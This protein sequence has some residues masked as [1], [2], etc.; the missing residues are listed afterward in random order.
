MLYLRYS[1]DWKRNAD[2]AIREICD[3][4]ASDPHKRILIVPE[5][6]SFD[7]ELA[8]CRA[9]GD[10]ISRYAEVL[11]FT[12][13][14]SRVFSQVGGAAI[15][16]LDKSGRLIAMA[17]ALEQLRPKLKLYGRHVTKPEFLQQ[18]LQVVDEFHGYGLRSEDVRR[19]E[20]LL[21]EPLTEKLEELCLILESYDAVCAGAL[22][23]ASTRLDRLRDAIYD[24][25]YGA[26]THIV[27]EGFTDFTN[28][29]LQVLEALMQKAS[30]M[31]VYLTLDRP[32]GGQTVFSVPRKTAAALRE[33]ARRRQILFRLTP[34]LLPEEHTEQR[35]LSEQLFSAKLTPWEGETHRITL[36]HVRSAAEECNAML[37]SV[38]A[39]LLTGARY[40]DIAIAYTDPGL[41]R[42]IL[43]N[44]LDR[45]GIPAY[46]SGSDDIM[47]QPV[48]RCVLYALEAA[49]C[50]MEARSISEYLKSGFAPVDPDQAD[51]LENY[52]FVWQLRGS[53]WEEPFDRHPTGFQKDKTTPP[54]ELEQ[55]LAPLNLARELAIGPV[56]A[57]KRG[58][59]EAK[60][61]AAQVDVLDEFL[62]AV[63]INRQLT[64]KTQALENAGL[65]QQAQALSQL[66]AI[67]LGTM[68]QIYGV[69]GK[70]V[71]TPDEFFRLFRAALTQNTVGTVPTTLD[72]VRV[73]QLSAM[74]NIRV[75]HL[76]LLGAS[77][78]LLPSFE[79]SAGLISDTERRM[80]KAA[81]LQTA[82][83]DSERL[84][85]ELLTAYTVMTAPTETLFLSCGA[86]NPSYLFSRM[87]KLFPARSRAETTPMPALPRQLTALLAAAPE[88]L[89]TAALCRFPEQTEPVAELLTRAAYTP[90]T[91]EPSAVRALYGEYLRLDAS[92]VEKF[93][94]CKY[95][96]YLRYGLAVREQKVAKVDASL[97]G[98]F[99]HHVLECTVR[100]V[101]EE[102]GFRAVSLERT[103]EVA[104]QSCN[105][106]AEERLNGLEDYSQ[107]VA[108]LFRRNYREVLQIVRDLYE[109]MRQSKFIPVSFEL[110]FEG[111][112]AI[113]ITGDLSM[114]SLKGYVDRVDLF[115][116]ASGKTYLR[117]VDYKSGKKE[118]NYA[119]VLEG[120]GLQMLIY[121]FALTEE[122]ERFYGQSLEPAGVLYLPARD[123]VQSF[124][125]R[126]EPEEAEKARR[127]SLKRNGLLL[128]DDEILAA[129]EPE[130]VAPVFLPY[131]F[132]KK[133][134][135]RSGDLADADRLRQ[136]E[137]HVSRI[138]GRFADEIYRGRIEPDPYW[139]NEEHNA[140]RWCEYREV[141]HVDS[142]EVSLRRRKSL[143]GPTFWAALDKED[144]KYGG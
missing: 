30:R 108:Y 84:D 59:Q 46:Y 134:Q 116:T 127:K 124:Q 92:K 132:V 19:A 9:G 115:T 1:R 42:P 3:G 99:V 45:S 135:S 51:R 78:G 67:L 93:A 114:G 140:C 119:E 60:N 11:S 23:D 90:G 142:G 139:R 123:N 87:E 118:F 104:E 6:N 143:S 48:I 80:M 103:L 17:A 7:A 117:V 110:P 71:R 20:E 21:S 94:S 83:E 25:D 101:Q 133:Y 129:M 88:A 130:T 8:L 77:D 63:G 136:L 82:P 32:E 39:R 5:Q 79:I 62:R 121:L 57:L 95:A 96:Y 85:R 97:F 15:A 73:G 50:G 122:A 14:A 40:R 16:T 36:C 75:R 126:P 27:V 65:Q 43:E 70:T 69:L 66:Y 81:G 107:R 109:E 106:F 138:L 29:E 102:G 128:E 10:E 120:L 34:L 113:P 24:S 144:E 137:R 64:E 28:Q 44:L 53:R 58:L 105:Q 89:R 72:R 76:L 91:L 54:E 41:Y 111:P 35:Q 112:T 12:R 4:A 74:R 56:S 38:Q 98:V 125:G 86:E 13:L 141:C 22:Q 55:L 49:A 37:A 52:G 33:L 61:T 47:R 2:E 18:L 68:E 131:K 26:M 31:T 100:T